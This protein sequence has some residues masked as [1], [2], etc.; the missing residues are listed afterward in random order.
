MKA[1]LYL[2]AWGACMTVEGELALNKARSLKY[3]K[4][5]V[6]LSSLWIGS[7]KVDSSPEQR[8]NRNEFFFLPETASDVLTKNLRNFP[9]FGSNSEKGLLMS[10]CM[11]SCFSA[12]QRSPPVLVTSLED[13]L[14]HLCVTSA[15]TPPTLDMARMQFERSSCAAAMVRDRKAPR[16]REALGD[17]MLQ[18][19][20]SAHKNVGFKKSGLVLPRRFLAEKAVEPTSP[21][22]TKSR[23]RN[24]PVG[25]ICLSQPVSSVEAVAELLPTS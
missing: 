13:V 21:A 18:N 19:R 14:L 17:V 4:S 11:R 24:I 8:G 10:C 9:R 6:K 22:E 23:I 3:E 20:F 12:V 7:N 1:V 16:T 5:R 25:S 2:L 15:Q